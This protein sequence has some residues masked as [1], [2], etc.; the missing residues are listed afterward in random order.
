MKLIIVLLTTAI[1]QVSASSFAQKLTYTQ[2]GATLKDLFKEIKRQTGYFVIYSV[3]KIDDSK[4]INAHFNNTDLKD[5]LDDLVKHDVLNYSIIDKNIVIKP[6][7]PSFLEKVVER[8]RA[9]D[10]RGKVTDEQGLPMPRVS[11]RLKNTD[12]IT[13]TNDNGEFSIEVPDA[14]SILQFSYLG[15]ASVERII[16]NNFFLNVT[17]IQ[18]TNT[19]SSVEVNAGYYRVKDR[20]R[21]G[22][23]SKV[24][25]ETIEKQSINNPIM[26][27]VGTTTGVQVTQQSGVPGR[28]INVQ[29][30]GKNSITRGSEPLYIVDGVIFSSS[31]LPTGAGSNILGADG[32]SP[33]SMINPADIESIEILK[34]ADATSIYGSRG[35]N[36]VVLITTKRNKEEKIK[37]N[38]SIIKGISEVGHTVKLLNTSQYLQMRKEAYKND[39]LNIGTGDYD[40]NGTYSQEGYTDW[41]KELIGGKAQN[42]NTSLNVSG[43]SKN[44]SYLFSGNFYDEGVVFPGNFG[45]NRV[46]LRSNIN[47]GSIADRFSASFVANYSHSRSKLPTTD[48]TGYILLAPNAPNPYDEFGRLTWMNNT[49]VV[50][51]MSYLL[52]TSDSGTGN[53]VGNL[54]LN[55]NISKKLT[56]KTS[57]GYSTII[58][59]EVQINPLSA[60]SP[61]STNYLATRRITYF[62]DVSNKNFIAEPI[63]SFISKLFGGDFNALVGMSLQD[64]HNNA[65]SIRA[66]NFTSDDLMENIGSASLLETSQN[67]ISQYRYIAGF[68]RLN[69]SL[70]NKYFLNVTAR[71]D[72]SSRFGQDKQF[73]NF[74]AIGLAWI[75]SDE[76]LFKNNLSIL[77]FGKIRASYGITGNDQISDYGYLQVWNTGS[78]YQGSPTVTPNFSAPNPDFSWELTK[79][80]EIGLQLGFYDNKLKLETAFYRN[81]SSNQL[82]NKFLPLSTGLSAVVMN[83]PATVQNTGWEFD[84]SFQLLKTN[85]WEWITSVNLTLPKNKLLSYPNLDKSNDAINYQ[86]GE[87]LSI[88]K[89]FNVSVNPQ[90]GLYETED[91]N[92]NGARDNG[93]RYIV[94]F[95][96]QNLYG[97]LSNKLSY[98]QF[99]LGLLLSFAKQNGRSY[100][101]TSTQT[102][103]VGFPTGSASLSNRFT[104]V[105]NRWQQPNE[106]TSTQ[107]FST[108]STNSS[109]FATISRNGNI[110]V[111]DAS[112]IR[113]RNIYLSYSLPKLFL[114]KVKI[115]SAEITLQGQNIFTI[116]NYV[117]LDPETQALTLPPLRTIS[118]G[119]NVTF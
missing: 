39:G 24:T 68:T 116:T 6:K 73:A 58:K 27:L 34:D 22:S 26:A 49:V 105:L 98:K 32:T 33:L 14:K 36:G 19:L 40:I 25:A 1:L 118:L 15:Y 113:L 107:K 62:T 8:F 90:T 50:N 61:F 10:I 30:R 111:V 13:Q 117:G 18:E 42:I 115:S 57:L 12:K 46:S 108:S 54:T 59:N 119:L 79:K 53:F 78:T 67:G 52:N 110:S 81:R 103:G 56:F 5:V 104:E 48:L 99:S 64:N 76:N 43:G 7:A 77:K 2:K 29:I 74:G 9:I 80:L 41:Q 20:D 11:I 65:R 100:L 4:K 3:D 60:I 83:L 96:G 109:L 28:N 94:K 95:L 51:P 112:F 84:S 16:E 87:P 85:T 101:L 69:Y 55:Y 21:T 75:F 102:P 82:L 114:S 45:F 31:P 35:A 106:I 44:M 71:R 97:G 88:I 23:I 86:I 72:G 70:N 47:I 17:L 91:Y 37:V 92:K 66:S 38:A 89:V 63:I 93:D